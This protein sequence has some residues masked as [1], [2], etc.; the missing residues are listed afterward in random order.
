M[1]EQI[2]VPLA[3]KERT[4]CLIDQREYVILEAEKRPNDIDEPIT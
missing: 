3:I 2:Y 4:F 1:K